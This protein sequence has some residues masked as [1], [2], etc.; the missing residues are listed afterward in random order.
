[1]H[2]QFDESTAILAGD[3][4]LTYAFQLIGRH[5]ADT[6]NIGMELLSIIGET[7]GSE[8]LIG[9]QV[10]D[11]LGESKKLTPE[12]LDYIH[13]NKTSAMIEASI[14]L[15][16]IAGQADE[17]QFEALQ[18]YGRAIGLAFQI[19]DDILDATSDTQTMGKTVGSDAQ[20]NKT[21]Y[22]SLHGLERSR[23]FANS[24]TQ[25]ALDACSELEGDTEFLEGL[26]NYL[27]TRIN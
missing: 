23:D 13:L 16:A 3:A 12:E 22:V 1:S 6:P 21:T 2:K 17:S 8:H 5:Y 19:I 27:N 24:L 20:L 15:G 18:Q 25:S 9:G 10:E 14:G 7:A 11:I 4:L 26:A